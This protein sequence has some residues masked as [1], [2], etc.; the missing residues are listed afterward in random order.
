M[1]SRLR[2]RS[3]AWLLA[4]LC[5]LPAVAQDA[6]EA[7][8]VPL[9]V[10]N[11]GVVLA[12]KAGFTVPFTLTPTGPRFALAPIAAALGVELR[13][14]PQG[15]S[16]TLVFGDANFLV[17]PEEPIMVVV[18]KEGEEEIVR[19]SGLPFR[20]A[21]G[22]KVPLDFL[23]R[24]FGE[25]LNYRFTWNPERTELIIAPPELRFVDGSISLRHDFGFSF[26]EIEFS[27]RPRYRVVHEP[28]A[29]ILELV[30]D[31][32][33]SPLRRRNLDDPLVSGIIA[34]QDRIRIELQ[35][36]AT[37]YE[38]RLR[39]TPS[40]TLTVEVSAASAEA[41]PVAERDRKTGRE[42]TR[43][44]I[45][46]IVLDPGHGGEETGAVGRSGTKEADLA[47]QVGRALK[48]ELERRLP[49]NVLLTRNADI[50]VPHDNRTAIANQNKADLFIS[51]HFNSTFGPWAQGAET[52]FL[53]RDASDELA[54]AAAEEENLSHGGGDR[55]DLDLQ[56]ILWDLAQSFHLAESQRFANLVQEEL[57]LSLGLRDRGVKQAPFRVLMGAKMPAVLVEL[58]FLSNPEEESKLQSPAYVKKLVDSLVRAVIRFKTQMEAREESPGDGSQGDGP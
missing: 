35:P 50:H 42:Q 58:G 6:G 57:N 38:P 9:A 16:H 43:E 31:R 12:G 10:G 47:L 20:D 51:L 5:V 26:V 33:R 44:G 1:G 49:V 25:Q 34:E 18:P 32:L 53:S 40:I 41:P 7:P 48:R 4:V 28:G 22:L 23:E 17:G 55:P 3:A 15:A 13:I 29:L 8:A 45:R 39:L 11:A 30:G 54:A 27:E 37:A 52:Y 46:T 36:R 56:L 21:Q 14:G 2:R 19:L 24:T